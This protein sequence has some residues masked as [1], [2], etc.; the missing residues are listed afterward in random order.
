M[1]EPVGLSDPQHV[2]GGLQGRH[3]GILI[4]RIG[5]HEEHV[6]DRLGD[7]ARHGRRTHVLDLD[8]PRPERGPDPVGL[9]L[10]QLRPPRVVIHQPDRPNTGLSASMVAA[11]IRSSVSEVRFSKGCASFNMTPG[12]HPRST[13]GADP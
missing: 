2:A 12:P 1:L 10:E 13:T 11:R 8:G 5:H 6:D 9:M 7:E 4:G 3:I